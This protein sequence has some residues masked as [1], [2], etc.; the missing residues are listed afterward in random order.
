MKL[1]HFVVFHNHLYIIYSSAVEHTSD[2]DKGQMKIPNFNYEY[3]YLYF[4]MF[5]AVRMN[6]KCKR[7]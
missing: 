3:C 7:D 1:T 4:K 2:V 6:I 5:K